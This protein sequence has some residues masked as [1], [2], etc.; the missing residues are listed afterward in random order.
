MTT[1]ISRY[2]RYR[3]GTFVRTLIN[4]LQTKVVW[5]GNRFNVLFKFLYHGYY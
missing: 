3:S 1:G 5:P 2:Q 4:P